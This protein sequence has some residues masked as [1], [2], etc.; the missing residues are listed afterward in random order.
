MLLIRNLLSMLYNK[1]DEA[2]K[3]INILKFFNLHTK[4]VK[5][6]KRFFNKLKRTLY[7]IISA[8]CRVKQS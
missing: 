7:Y 1:K 2:E 3:K 5:Y 8:K 6:E 4:G